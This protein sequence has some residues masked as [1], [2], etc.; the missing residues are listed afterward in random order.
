MD[1]PSAQG[2][3]P[4]ADEPQSVD[5]EGRP[6]YSATELME[7]IDYNWLRRLAGAKL[8]EAA[9]EVRAPANNRDRLVGRVCSGLL[10]LQLPSHLG[11]GENRAQ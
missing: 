7:D 10:R 4:M 1:R 6:R 8:R 11:R 9:G 5:P 2:I 3:S